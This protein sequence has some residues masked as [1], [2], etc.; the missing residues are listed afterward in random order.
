[1]LF[2]F[3]LIS[4]SGIFFAA[5]LPTHYVAVSRLFVSLSEEY[6]FRPRVGGEV[7]NNVPELEELIQTEIELM[8]SPIVIERAV[9]TFGMEALYPGQYAKASDIP[10]TLRA[11]V[12][13]EGIS[14]L[15]PKLRDDFARA[16]ND[17]EAYIVAEAA[18]NRMQRGF[19]A[20]A[21]PKQ[22]V[23]QTSF[24]H[25]DAARASTFLNRLLSEYLAYR[26]T[27]FERTGSSS[28][29]AQR[30]RFET[31]LAVVED[32]MRQFL[33]VHDIADFDAERA[34]L[35]TLYAT[36][37]AAILTNETR[38]SQLNG[39]IEVLRSQLSR[40]PIEINLFVEDSSSQSLT[41]LELER[42]DLLTRYTEESQ[43][44]QDINA[45][46][47]RA[48]EYLDGQDRTLGTIRRGRNPLHQ[49]IQSNLSSIS[50][51][52]EATRQ[53]YAELTRQAADIRVRQQ[54]IVDLEPE[55]QKLVRERTLLEASVRDA[56]TREVEARTLAEIA[57]QDSDN[58]R[59][60]EEARQPVRGQSFKL[61]VAII[62]ILF[63]AFCALIVGLLLALTRKGFATPKS[64]ER[65][66]GLPVVTTVPRYK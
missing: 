17:A 10:E 35:Q 3:I 9:Q 4:A 38:Q 25:P 30:L 49:Q 37:E 62:S 32:A 58:I 2:I 36:I 29:E 26:G 14:Q 11:E 6:V 51:E 52:A 24:K 43:T 45:R 64:L 7:F 44:V 31:D 39:Q 23:I 21:T 57:A 5:T 55:W 63:G 19:T 18:L 42:E 40:T 66:L 27:I 34:A 28:L 46:I 15:Y 48:R 22:S 54:R 59:I 12:T 65:T 41:N 8:H 50:S 33:A 56:S 13:E 60:L 1:M 61:I 47:T 20:F 53:Q 16:R